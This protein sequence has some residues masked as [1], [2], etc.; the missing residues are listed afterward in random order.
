M[1]GAGSAASGEK[2]Q[3]I[4]VEEWSSAA[5]V[6]REIQDFLDGRSDGSVLLDALYG[7]TLGEM[8]PPRLTELLA[9]WRVS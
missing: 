4:P 6:E 1:A 8:L 7:D 3:S 5:A 9:K 2:A